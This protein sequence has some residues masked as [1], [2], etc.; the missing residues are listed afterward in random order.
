MKKA[1]VLFLAMTLV[2][3]L[4]SPCFAESA[5]GPKT[6]TAI[7]QADG[8]PDATSAQTAWENAAKS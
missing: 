1:T 2:F 3:T 7:I 8:I 4:A 5:P 6:E